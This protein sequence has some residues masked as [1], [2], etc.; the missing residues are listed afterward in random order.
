MQLT[1]SYMTLFLFSTIGLIWKRIE[2]SVGSKTVACIV[3]S[4][5]DISFSS[6]Q[7]FTKQIYVEWFRLLVLPSM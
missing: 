5:L 7:V 2:A 1:V 4:D 3:C 6:F